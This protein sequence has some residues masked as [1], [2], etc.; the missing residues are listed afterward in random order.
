MKKRF[1]LY[2]FLTQICIFYAQSD[3]L[4]II[5][6]NYSH[7]IED[8][9]EE[10]DSEHYY[11]MIE[12]LMNN[13]VDLNNADRLEFM[14]I[15]FLAP[16]DIE[17]I[18]SERKKRNGFNNTDELIS[19]KN[20][21]PDLILIIKPF[22]TVNDY[23]TQKK[24]SDFF[25]L[26]YRTRLLTDL[27][28]RKGFTNNA[29]EG[30]SLKS[31]NRIKGQSGKFQFGLLTEKDAGEKSYLDHYAGF[32]KYNHGGIL[33]ELIIGDFS[34]EFGQGLVLWSPYSFSKGTDAVN[35]S[36]K[37]E[38]NFSPYL[39]SEENKFFRGSAFSLEYNSFTLAGFYSSK[40]IDGRI[41]DNNE[42]LSLTSTGYHRTETELLNKKILT[43]TSFGG[44]VHYR[45]E[46]FSLGLLLF[47]ESFNNPFIYV[48]D[49][50][51]SGS[52][53]SFSSLNFNFLLSRIQFVGEISYNNHAFAFINTLFFSLSKK[54][55]LSTSYRNYS[56]KYYNFYSNG[57]GEFGNTQNESGFYM[58]LKL[59]MNIGT[60]N[61][62]Y[63]IYKSP[64]QSYYSYFPIK[65]NDL[66]F[67]FESDISTNTQLRIKFKNEEKEILTKSGKNEAIGEEVKINFRI[68]LKYKLSNIL[69]GKSR[70]EV[71]KYKA[72]KI[73]EDG[74]LAFQEL[75]YKLGR[76]FSFSVRVILFQTE[77]YNS[78]IY[79]FEND[80]IGTMTNLPMFGEGFR[81]Y[82]LVNYKLLT[83]LSLSLK[84]S[85]T[86][87]PLLK[88]ISSGNSEI[89][90]NVDNRVSFQFDYNF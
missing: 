59:K 38:R 86:F 66:M 24:K 87:K 57:F 17:I 55:R 68:G 31:Y 11:E 63:D 70:I 85:D 83:T 9:S 32:L 44:S 18:I 52:Q 40:N 80:L 61:F 3:T 29:F 71:I 36:I 72:D 34:F 19:V 47:K 58:G 4:Q 78:R 25:K 14:K 33:K 81:F 84:Y 50:D 69:F 45:E 60:L 88:S 26:Q 15:P 56:P 42:I 35:T 28:I 20:L 22:L 49:N 76:Q 13:P 23:S 12:E 2:L 62:Y 77:S 64:A 6:E 82:L 16:D 37:R 46:Y 8:L 10:E 67:N 43:E 73:T 51:L 30:N 21:H 7:L 54:I 90:G 89:N 1:I 48:N 5:N 53:F 74:I 75:G 79:E 39:S 27:Q 65:G 41:N